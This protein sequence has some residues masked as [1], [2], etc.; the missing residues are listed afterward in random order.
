MENCGFAALGYQGL[1]LV[2]SQLGFA[3]SLPLQCGG[4]VDDDGDWS[5]HRS[6]AG[7]IDEET[8]AVGCDRKLSESVIEGHTRKRSLEG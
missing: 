1:G 8:L 2:S 6:G 4:P 5:G 7:N 3:R